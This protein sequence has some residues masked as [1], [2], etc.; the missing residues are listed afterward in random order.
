MLHTPLP[1]STPAGL[2][3]GDDHVIL[4]IPRSPAGRSTPRRG[5]RAAD[6]GRACR[7]LEVELM[8]VATHGDGEAGAASGSTC[9]C[10]L[11]IS[12]HG[13]HAAALHRA[14]AK[15][16]DLEPSPV[17]NQ[18]RVLPREPAGA[19]PLDGVSPRERDVVRLLARGLTMK[20][21]A[22]R[23]GIAARTVAFHKYRLMRRLSVRS[24]AELVQYAV[25][26]RLV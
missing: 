18:A 8:S 20:E 15:G 9:D 7:R 23:L 17:A 10:V 26:R 3:M 22:A 1:V 5:S 14:L 19:A 2:I 12:V 11:T 4:L 16:A 24:S 13:E 21:A 25:R 6:R